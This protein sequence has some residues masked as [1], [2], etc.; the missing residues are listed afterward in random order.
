MRCRDSTTTTMAE[1][2]NTSTDDR[3]LNAVEVV[4]FDFDG[5]NLD[6]VRLPDGDVGVCLRRLSDAV[7]V[8]HSTQHK[9]LRRAAAAGGRWATV[10]VLT[11]VANDG[12]S[13]RMTVLPRRS[14]PM[15]AATLSFNHVR[16]SHRRRVTEKL[17]R[18][19]DRCADVLADHFLGPRVGDATQLLREN[20]ALEARVDMLVDQTSS[21]LIGRHRARLWIL[22]PLREAARYMCIAAHDPSMATFMRELKTA[23]NEVRLHVRYPAGLAQ[24]WEALPIDRLGDAVSKVLEIKA[25]AERRAAAKRPLTTLPAA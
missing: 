25:R 14:I 23:D 19:Q 15:W 5:D 12:K 20:A 8:D 24:R 4:A 16:K 13:R 7:G 22:S 3:A 18:Y 9:R 10:V 6:V 11:T 21:G 1:E 2:P 17:A